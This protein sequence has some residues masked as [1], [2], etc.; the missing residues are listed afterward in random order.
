MSH[1]YLCVSWVMSHIFVCVMSH[2]PSMQSSHDTHMDELSRCSVCCSV[3][4]Q[5]AVAARC[6]VLQCVLQSNMDELI[7]CSVCCSVLLQCAV[8]ARCSVLQC[9]LQSNM[10]D[11]S[12]CVVDG[13]LSTV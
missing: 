10:D 11:L 1:T 5:C 13:A 4:L 3:L 6:S 8:A 7:R 2:V 9:V 12:H